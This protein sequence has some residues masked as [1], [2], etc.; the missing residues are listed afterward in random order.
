MSRKQRRMLK[1]IIIATVLFLVVLISDLVLKH[2]FSNDFKYGIASIIPNEAYGWLLPFGM[3]FLIYIFIGH[4]VLK[5]SVLNIIFPLCENHK[6]LVADKI[7][8]DTKKQISLFIKISYFFISI[9]FFLVCK[10]ILKP[11]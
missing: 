9:I 2:A 5:K 4:N 6:L 7:T 11:I 8:N 1:D 10:S 3:Y